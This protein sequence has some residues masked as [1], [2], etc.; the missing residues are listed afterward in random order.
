[1][2][3]VA[4]GV[5]HAQEDGFLLLLRNFKSLAAPWIPVH[6]VSGV[7]EQ[8]RRF[9]TVQSIHTITLAYFGAVGEKY[10]PWREYHA[11]F[12]Q[13]SSS[14]SPPTLLEPYWKRLIGHLFGWKKLVLHKVRPSRKRAVSGREGLSG[15]A[16]SSI[17]HC[18][19][20]P[21][22]EQPVLRL[23]CKLYFFTAP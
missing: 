12:S 13:F 10:S 2:A 23:K 6:G 20:P 22:S 1:M 16:A 21:R 3:P 9:F 5:T 4:G 11:T 7:L 14:K 19:F 15:A 18:V 17:P 8:V